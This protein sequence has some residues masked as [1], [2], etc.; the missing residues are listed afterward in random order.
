MRGRAVG[1]FG[2]TF[3]PVHYGHLRPALEILEAL[4][5]DR[6]LFIP[7]REPPHRGPPLATPAQRLAMLRLAVADQPGF[8]IDERELA[9]PGPSYSV[10]TLRSLRAELGPDLPLCLIVG[11]DAFLGLGSWHRWE[12]I[13][14]LA[15]LVVAHRP[16]WRLE[17]GERGSE[18]ALSWLRGHQL[19]EPRLL[20]ERPAGGVWLQPVTPLD[21]SA[22]GIRAHVGRGSSPRY[23]LPDPVWRYI[24][25]QGL[26]RSRN[27]EGLHGS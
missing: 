4:A 1:L 24:Q 9:R 26:Y 11:L 13:P 7:A 12:E 16:G 23:L 15:N 10:D 21:I 27:L 8:V 19:T 20:H 18:G 2:G 3:D 5:L 14:T 17:P 25:E 6:L 22:T